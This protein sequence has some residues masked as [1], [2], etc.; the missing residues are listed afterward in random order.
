M[1]DAVAMTYV[2]GRTKAKYNNMKRFMEECNY[3]QQQGVQ[4]LIDFE[5]YL[6][7][8]DEKLEASKSS[9]NLKQQPLKELQ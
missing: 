6:F 7:S 8:V 2:R 4:T 9:M 5:K 3:L 1:H